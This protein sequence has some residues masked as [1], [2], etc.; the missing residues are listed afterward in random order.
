VNLCEARMLPK[1]AISFLLLPVIAGNPVLLT[2]VIPIHDEDK[3]YKKP[4]DA[5][6]T[7]FMTLSMRF[8]NSFKDMG[9]PSGPGRPPSKQA[10][11]LKILSGGRRQRATKSAAPAA[12]ASDPAC[13]PA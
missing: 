13:Q 8:I 9:R 12:S 4:H 1:R 3:V 2:S 11:H 5:L 6:K 7:S 10:R